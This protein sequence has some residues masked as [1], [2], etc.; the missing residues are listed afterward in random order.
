MAN[1]AIRAKDDKQPKSSFA[2]LINDKSV[3]KLVEPTRKSVN[4]STFALSMFSDARTFGAFTDSAGVKRSPFEVDWDKHAVVV[5]VL[6]EHTYRLLFK[7][8]TVKDNIGQ[9]VFYWDGIEP[10]YGDRFPV[11]MYRIDKKGLK[12]V[13]VKGDFDYLK[14]AVDG[15]GKNVAEKVLG[16]IPCP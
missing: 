2:G 11:V 7:E 4:G 16:E 14:L 13:V 9:L 8:W 1:V 6:E 10:E 3:D 12:K 5:V 15:L